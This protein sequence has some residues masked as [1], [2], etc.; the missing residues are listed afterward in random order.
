MSQRVQATFGS[1]LKKARKEAARQRIRQDALAAALEISRTSISNIER[2]RHRVFLD[3]VYAAARAL[4]VEVADLLPTMEEVFPRSAV[5]TAGAMPAKAAREVSEMISALR[6][7]AVREVRQVQV[8]GARTLT[9]K[10]RT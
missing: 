7:R 1:R 8:S 3:Q 2:G 6:E 5:S 9:S 4:G 10:R